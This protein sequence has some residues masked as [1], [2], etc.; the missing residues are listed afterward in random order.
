MAGSVTPRPGKLPQ[1]HRCAKRHQYR[2]ISLGETTT[3]RPAGCETDLSVVAAHRRHHRTMCWPGRDQRFVTAQ[4]TRTAND[5][6]SHLLDR[7]SL[8]LLYPQPLAAAPA[9]RPARWPRHR[10][11]RTRQITRFLTFRKCPRCES[12]QDWCTSGMVHAVLRAA[13]MCVVCAMR[14]YYVV[15]CR[16]SLLSA[17]H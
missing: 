4:P 2:W 3:R 6:G 1:K 10:L 9:S 15:H 7:T 17:L 5:D 12:V 14:T 8:Q 13:D 16:C 11:R